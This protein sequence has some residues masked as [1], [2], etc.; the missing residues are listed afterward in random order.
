MPPYRGKRGIAMKRSV[1]KRTSFVPSAAYQEQSHAKVCMH[2]F[3]PARTSV[4]TMRAATALVKAGMAVSVVDFESENV[5]PLIEERDGI[6]ITH[7]VVPTWS[8]PTRFKPWFLIKSASMFGTRVFAL[9]RSHAD[10]YHAHDAPALFACYVA[11]WLRRKPVIFEA[12]ELPWSEPYFSESLYRRVLRTVLV[13]FLHVMI[14]R[15]AGVITVS[16][17]LA[18]ELQRRYGSTAPVLV[19]NI[20]EYRIPISSDR[21]RRHLALDGTTPIA[22]FQGNL[23]PD[24]ALDALVRAARFLAPG[25]VIA[26]LGGGRSRA[27]LETLIAEEGVEERVKILPPVP[28][29]ELLD[30]TASADIGL[31]IYPDVYSDNVR[32]FLPHKLFEY[33]M[34]GLPVLASAKEAIVEIIHEYGVGVVVESL[35]AER[36]GQ[37]ISTMIADKEALRVMRRNALEAAQRELRWDVESQRLI[38]LYGD[39]LGLHS[40]SQGTVGKLPS[41]SRTYSDGT[42]H[43]DWRASANTGGR[44]LG[45]IRRIV[46]PLSEWATSVH[47]KSR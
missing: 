44:P 5:R 15:C 47:V 12:Y 27:A 34:A 45:R 9:L 8:V 24:R 19:R 1:S 2:V 20:P 17:P 7:I 36:L 46:R 37:T 41:M 43:A 42:R 28:Q 6:T 14:P 23:Q 10:V 40:R 35:D 38:T 11:A 18:R 25:I 39:V 29:T 26:L 21:L 32:M 13:S 22:L 4:R 16:P 31:A 30:W 33:I 3:R